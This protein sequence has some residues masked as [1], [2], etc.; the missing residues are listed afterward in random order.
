MKFNLS[1]PIRKLDGKQVVFNNK[2]QTLGDVLIHALMS[3]LP[4]SLATGAQKVRAYEL[5]LAITKG[6]EVEFTHEDIV[7]IKERMLVVFTALIYGQVV[8]LLENG[9]DNS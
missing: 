3:E 4:N 2:K 1:T 7:F 6:E 8:K 9:T 5:S